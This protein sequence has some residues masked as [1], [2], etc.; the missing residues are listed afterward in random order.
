LGA[1]LLELQGLGSPK[2][3]DGAYPTPVDHERQHL[4]AAGPIL[5]QYLQR[6]LTA[7]DHGNEPLGV[8]ED[9][10]SL[11]PGD[12]WPLFDSGAPQWNQP[13]RGRRQA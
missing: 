1:E 3:P 12:P 5:R 4:A 6:I 10:A 9:A 13:R 11:E 2:R 8:I 7:R